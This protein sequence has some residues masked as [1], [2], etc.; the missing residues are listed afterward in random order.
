MRYYWIIRRMSN[1]FDYRLKMVEHAQMHGITKASKA[2]ETTRV[3]VRK[4]LR[5]YEYAGLEG[6]RDFSRAPKRIPHKMS[7]EDESNVVYLREKH[8][9]WGAI[10]IKDRYK[11][12]RSHT[13][14]HRVFKQR[15]LIK[16]KR[17]KWRKRRNLS[18]LKRKLKL[19]EKNQ[20]DVKDL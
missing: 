3:T 7:D 18:K 6:L 10:R 11:I 4:W 12:A 14:I 8:K 19:F 9:K 1:K 5:R 2:F 20:V 16:K 13:A 17:R 15:G